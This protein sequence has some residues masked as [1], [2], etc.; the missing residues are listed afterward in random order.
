MFSVFHSL[1]A[2]CRSLV[3]P[4]E[5]L[6]RCE[7]A[8]LLQAGGV[9]ARLLLVRGH[10]VV[11]ADQRENS[12]DWRAAKGPGRFTRF[13][14][15]GDITNKRGLRGGVTVSSIFIRRDPDLRAQKQC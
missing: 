12:E 6:D 11:P 8:E 4:I 7:G 1:D 2:V 3:V 14:E 15:K 9:S 13:V 5:V 10:F